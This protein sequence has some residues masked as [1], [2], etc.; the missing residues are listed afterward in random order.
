M[1]HL[2]NIPGRPAFF[3]RGNGKSRSGGAGRW[4]R[5]WEEW[6]EG[7]LRWSV[8]YERRIK[9]LIKK[10]FNLVINKKKEIFPLKISSNKLEKK[11][12]YQQIHKSQTETEETWNSKATLYLPKLRPQH[13]AFR[14]SDSN[15]IPYEAQT[16]TLYPRKFRSPN[17]DYTY[18]GVDGMMNQNSKDYFK[19]DQRLK[20][21][22]DGS[23]IKSTSL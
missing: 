7:K 21:W 8:M 3:F 5:S 22:R 2:V 14:S 23:V 12:L 13:Y 16:P 1:L 10:E 18:T 17:T 6:R 9:K 15:T 11:W 20:D 4:G 19:N